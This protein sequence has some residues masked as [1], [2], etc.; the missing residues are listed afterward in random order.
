MLVYSLLSSWLFVILNF[1][2]LLL[3]CQRMLHFTGEQRFLWRTVVLDGRFH[4]PFILRTNVPPLSYFVI[5]LYLSSPLF[6][7]SRFLFKL[8][9]LIYPNV[10]LFLFPP[11][12]YSPPVLL[13]N[14]FLLTLSLWSP[15]FLSH[16]LL[17]PTDQHHFSVLKWHISVCLSE[18]GNYGK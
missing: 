13:Y 12:I 9:V 7:S 15:L 17:P 16:L 2:I 10:F 8:F 4:C 1:M 6:L 14:A 18:K 11:H 3:T 5:S